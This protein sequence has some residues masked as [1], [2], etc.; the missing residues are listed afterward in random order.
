[1]TTAT[2]VCKQCNFENEPE[3]VYCHN[4]GAK[5]D[6]S[7][8]PPEATKRADPVVVQERVRKM[9][10]PRR[11]S[12]LRWLRNLVLSLL[13]AAV[14]GLVAVM[15]Q[16][17]DDIPEISKDAALS[18]PTIT[19]DMEGMVTQP[20]ASRLVYAED[21]VNAFL[22]ST[23][24]G[25]P[26]SSSGVTPLKFERAYVH[27]D[28]GLVRITYVQSVFGFPLY[29][30]TVDGVTIQN[31]QLAAQPVAGSF[32]RVK[33]PGK[34][35]PYLGGLFSPL[36]KVLDRDKNLIARMESITFHKKT[37]ERPAAVEM[38]SKAGGR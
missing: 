16:P 17:P 19:D 11:G 8:L 34:L 21:K 12:G 32:G 22:Q 27:F 30:T 25:K 37:A 7:L 26:D 3:R 33:I 9:V 10:S 38:I 29:A 15:I 24:H 14:L 5:L 4:C 13:I 6:R 18:A 23:I 20:S 1:M 35:M 31:G 2:L 28:E 36:W